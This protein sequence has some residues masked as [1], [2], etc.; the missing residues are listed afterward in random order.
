MRLNWH[1]IGAK[2]GSWMQLVKIKH[3]MVVDIIAVEAEVEAV[4]VAVAE[5]PNAAV[6]VAMVVED[7]AVAPGEE[8]KGLGMDV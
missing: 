1:T 3:C 5:A 2:E 4:D 8:D 7:E 6:E